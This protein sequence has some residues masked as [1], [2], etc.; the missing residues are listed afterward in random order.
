MR[1][2][3]MILLGVLFVC[4][5]IYRLSEQGSLTPLESWIWIGGMIVSMLTITYLPSLRRR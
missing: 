5:I 3:F 4:G 2:L 1:F